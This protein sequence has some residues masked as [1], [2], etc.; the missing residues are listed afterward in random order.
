MAKGMLV[1]EFVALVVVLA[2]VFVD[3]RRGGDEERGMCAVVVNG[4]GYPCKEYTVETQDGFLLGLQRISH[5]IE[6]RGDGTKRMPVLLQHGLLQ[7]GDN[8]VL[9]LPGQSLG[10]ILADEGFDVWIANGRG[11]RWSHGH[12]TY[13]KHDREYWDWTWDELAEYD[14][15][16]MLEFVMTTTG[17]KVFYVG[18]SQGT[19]MGLASF[20]QPVVTDMLAA[21]ALL[22][23]ITYLDHISSNFINAAAH[24]YIDRMV[25]TMGVREFNLRNE[26]GVKLMDYVCQREDVDCGNLLAAITGPNCCFN[27]TR[28]PYYLQFEPHSTSLKNLAHLAQM[29]RRG[30]FA[31]YDYGILGNLQHYLS[32]S[33]PD[34]DL[35]IIPESLPLW[36]ASGGND[37]LADPVDVIR[38]IEQLRSTPEV[39]VLPE[40]G[41]I[42]FVLSIQAKEDLYDS[43][44]AFFRAHADRCVLGPAQ[45]TRVPE[46]SSF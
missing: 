26:V 25:K 3:G 7:G 1:F 33:P 9:N 18:H 41:H 22:S 39:I 24:H 13:S 44:I 28:I 10:F 16:A 30:T 31:K 36:M 45:V 8:W 11:T 46:L 12:K 21:A 6:R 42:D 29:I 4:T 17:S 20:S 40:Y 32:L 2:V 19:I 43:M 15:P 14:L 27:G 37:A 38:T 23:P 35:T 5:G 34:Y